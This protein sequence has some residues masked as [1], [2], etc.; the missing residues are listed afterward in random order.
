MLNVK[1]RNNVKVFGQGEKAIVFAH[2]FGCEQGMWQY[3]IPIF[4]N[5]YRLIVFDYVGSGGSDMTAYDAVKY[6][7]LS[8][9]SQD[10]LEII[11][12]LALEDVIFV[13]HSVSSMIGL[14]ASIQ[15]PTYFDKLVMIGPSPCYLNTEDGYHG[16]FE[17]SD[18]EDLLAMMEMNF[19]GWAS[20]MAPMALE[21]PIE[22]ETV[23]ELRHT[24]V[25]NDPKVARQFAEVTFYSDCRD[26]LKQGQ[27]DTLI[28]QCSSDSIVP[29]E[30]GEYLHQHLKNSRLHILDAKGHYPHISHPQE[31]ASVIK[32]YLEVN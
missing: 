32:D 19:T 4:E 13:G 28:L 17:K 26:L 31:T 1:E 14:F 23:K 10:V 21:Q 8:G 11:E 18:I 22:A 20:Y 2:G 5:N 29:I 27:V 25:S 12:E 7:E 30:V 16:G 24:F 3:I 9:Y 6:N 15:Q